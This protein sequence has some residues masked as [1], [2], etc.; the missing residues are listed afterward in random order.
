MNPNLFICSKTLL[1]L[2]DLRPNLKK[3]SLGKAK[4]SQYILSLCLG[5]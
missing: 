3:L 2:I 4:T 1:T 5:S